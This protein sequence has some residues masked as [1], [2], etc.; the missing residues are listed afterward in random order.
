MF[1]KKK[2]DRIYL[3]P[4]HMSGREQP[5]LDEVFETN[6]VSPVGPMLTRFE[7]MFCAATNFR[8][9]VAV[10]NGTAALHLALRCLGVKAGD[11][12]WAPSFTFIASVAPVIYQQAE[13]ILFDCDRENWNIDLSLIADQLAKAAK[14]GQLPKA[15]IT[16]DLYGQPVDVGRLRSLADPYGVAVIADA[17]EAMGCLRRGEHAGKGAVCAAFSFNGNKILT[18]GGGGILASDDRDLIERARNL[19]QQAR[20]PAPHYEHHEVGYNYRMS[21]LNAAVGSGQLEVLED[22]VAKRRAVFSAYRAALGNRSGVRF[23]E[24]PPDARANKWLT[25]LVLE[26]GQDPAA[27]VASLEQEGIE[28]RRLW[29]PMHCQ[30]AFAGTRRGGGGGA[31]DLF[32][33]GICLPS[34]SSMSEADIERVIEAF[35]RAANIF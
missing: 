4:P 17:A 32:A 26:G 14:A 2:Q 34:G 25:T 12:V 5:Y 35:S 29:K 19:S 15:I 30:K 28:A 16:V 7:E 27:I 20:V 23:L 8:H 11:R 3:S 13:L 9:A 1:D 18:A 24:E 6:F 21:S 31:E 10:V 33:R 22:R